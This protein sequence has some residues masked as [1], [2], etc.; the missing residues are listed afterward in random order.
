[1]QKLL[2][3]S[4]GFR[5]GTG[6]CNGDSGSGFI[7]QKDD[8]WTLRGIVSTSLLDQEQRSC[9]LKNYVVFTDVSKFMDW[10]LPHIR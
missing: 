4:A 1:M 2:F 8:R 6:P 7:L 5:N 10:L 3:Y 9:D